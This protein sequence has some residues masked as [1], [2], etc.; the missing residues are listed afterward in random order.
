MVEFTEKIVF[1][2][3]HLFQG[4]QLNLQKK[5]N[6]VYFLYLQFFSVTFIGLRA[7]SYEKNCVRSS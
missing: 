1:T 4:K 3:N 6:A 7:E 2:E 5:L